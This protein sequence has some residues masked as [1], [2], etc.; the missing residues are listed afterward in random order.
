MNDGVRSVVSTLASQRHPTLQAYHKGNP[1]RVERAR[2]RPEVLIH[3]V[4]EVLRNRIEACDEQQTLI[5]ARVLSP[6]A[7][8]IASVNT[9]A[10]FPVPSREA[11]ASRSRS[12]CRSLLK[13]IID[14][15]P[16]RQDD[17]ASPS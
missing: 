14:C 13:R 1:E 5:D 15:S 9:G 2:R 12:P 11:D 3:P 16:L 6:T 8:V 4:P 7:N 10:P 17:K